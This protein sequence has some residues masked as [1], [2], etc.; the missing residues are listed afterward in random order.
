MLLGR[1]SKQSLQ[2]ARRALHIPGKRLSAK[3]KNRLAGKP[4]TLPFQQTQELLC[5]HAPPK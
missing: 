3:S 4:T 1:F 2:A 5:T